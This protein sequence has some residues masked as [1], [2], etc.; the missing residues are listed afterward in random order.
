MHCTKWDLFY[1]NTERDIRPFV[2]EATSEIKITLW[3][4]IL[5]KNVSLKQMHLQGKLNR[6]YLSL[7]DSY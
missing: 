7:Q 1:L 5:M 4:S 3:H 2:L 6:N